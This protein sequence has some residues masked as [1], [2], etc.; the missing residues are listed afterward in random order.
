MG[1]MARI[2]VIGIRQSTDD[3]VFLSN[4]VSI[5]VDNFRQTSKENRIFNVELVKAK[6]ISGRTIEI[7]AH[8]S[9]IEFDCGWW[10]FW[11][12]NEHQHQ[13]I[14]DLKS[15][16]LKLQRRNDLAAI[17]PLTPFQYSTFDVPIEHQFSK[18]GIFLRTIAIQNNHCP[19]EMFK[20][21]QS[22]MCID[23]SFVCDGISDCPLSNDD[24]DECGD[25]DT[26]IFRP[27]SKKVTSKDFEDDFLWIER[28]CGPWYPEGRLQVIKFELP[29]SI[30]RHWIS[31]LYSSVRQPLQFISDEMQFNPRDLRP[32]DATISLPPL[33]RFGEIVSV[34][35]DVTNWTS[36]D[37]EVLV[38]LEKSYGYSVVSSMG[39]G[40]MVVSPESKDHH[41]VLI[42]YGKS[43]RRTF[44][45]IKPQRLGE[46]TV[47]VKA[48]SAIGFSRTEQSIK[49]ESEGVEVRFHTSTLISLINKPNQLVDF[50]LNI[51]QNHQLPL[52]WYYE[53]VPDSIKCELMITGDVNGPMA[54]PT[55]IKHSLDLIMMP[56]V[57]QA[58]F[59]YAQNLF[60]LGYCRGSARTIATCDPDEYICAMADAL[61]MI[62]RFLREDGSLDGSLK[63]TLL[64]IILFGD[65]RL[66]YPNIEQ[67]S[68]CGFTL[69]PGMILKLEHFILGA[70]NDFDD[71]TKVMIFM[72]KLKIP[73]HFDCP[74]NQSG[75]W[76][77]SIY[78]Y[79][80][81]AL[82]SKQNRNE[83]TRHA[84]EKLKNISDVPLKP[85]PDSRVPRLY[86]LQI[87]EPPSNFILALAFL[88]N[89]SEIFLRRM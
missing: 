66:L 74:K 52:N 50:S 10:S 83:F 35:I 68:T 67:T 21:R 58:V 27:W 85:H 14:D 6:D 84:I 37:I 64:V 45:P 69:D 11:S 15:Q 38:V 57:D 33:A 7:H 59:R 8:G 5:H 44:I 34:Q 86:P 47:I 3:D 9:Q 18:D 60:S 51:S 80:I 25:N 82:V 71:L 88:L 22:G 12:K 76:I 23:S 78:Y 26:I 70:A 39:D 55:D 79:S 41:L 2:L 32:F 1:P 31:G 29:K 16:V 17:W 13:V 24:E 49:V 28:P 61:S 40:L 77:D 4:S 36:D 63:F 65:T 89:G 19:G 53:H 46:V 62:S 87:T 75:N 20:C 30:D 43:S 42:M 54:L 48:Y 73:L 56:L 72:S 81:C